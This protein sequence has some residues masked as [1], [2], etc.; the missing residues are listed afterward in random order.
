MLIHSLLVHGYMALQEVQLWDLA[1]AR[2]IR[3][4]TGQRQG[5]NVIRSCFGGV[6]GNFVVSGSEG[7]SLSDSIFCMLYLTVLQMATFTCGTRIQVFSWKCWPDM[8]LV[9]SMTLPGIR[10]TPVCSHRAQTM[11]PFG[12]GKAEVRFCRGQDAL[13]CRESNHPQLLTKERAEKLP[14]LIWL[15]AP[16]NDFLIQS[17]CLNPNVVYI[18][19][20]QLSAY[21][22]RIIHCFCYSTSLHIA[23]QLLITSLIVH[24]IHALYLVAFCNPIP[25]F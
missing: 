18:V 25:T 7:A 5:Q 20:F 2:M 9:A 15:L 21:D 6:D 4:F 10:R 22:E 19:T 8:V 1:E 14:R 23:F 12:Y 3:K 16:Y 13:R 17:D 11:V 24:I